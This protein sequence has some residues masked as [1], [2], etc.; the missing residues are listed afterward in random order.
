M[1]TDF[2]EFDPTETAPHAPDYRRRV[3]GAAISANLFANVSLAGLNVALPAIARDLQLSAAGQ[4]W[5]ASSLLLATAA[6]IAPVAR[7]ADTWGRRKT[8]V[9]GLIIFIIASIACALAGNFAALMAGRAAMG[10]GLAMVFASTMA[11]A[12]SVYPPERRGLV[13][14][15]IVSAVYVGLAAGPGLCGVLADLWPWASIFWLSAALMLIPLILLLTVRGDWAAAG[16]EKYDYAGALLWA[17][18]L[19]AG[20]IGL[21]RLLE[22]PGQLM[23]VGG[24]LLFAAFVVHQLKRDKPILDLRLFASRRFA[25]S[26][27][28]AFIAYSAAMGGIFLLSLFLQYIKGLSPREAGLFLMLQPAVQAVL[29]PLAGRLSDSRDPG[30]VAAA[31]LAITTAACLMLYLGLGPDVSMAYILSALVVFG[32]GFAVFAAPNS[33]AVM[34]AVP[35]DK[36]GVAS[37]IITA[38]RLTGQIF[39]LSFTSLVFTLVIGPGLVSPEL[40]PQFIKAAKLC[41]LVF[42]PMVLTGCFLSLIKDEKAA[43]R[44]RVLK[45]ALADS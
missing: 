7:L 30:R 3:L 27:L 10:L 39:S 44:P 24:L 35:P 34:S 8:T 21:T 15:Y 45:K 1:Q 14:G 23:T 13:F 20:F 9:L 32:V 22:R 36:L 41:F 40:Y 4:V 33:N 31:G 25:W 19:L 38:T 42:T 12:A 29:T 2:E 26:S 18:A 37:G 16:G 5:V 6:A 28:A 11:L 43:G 17:A